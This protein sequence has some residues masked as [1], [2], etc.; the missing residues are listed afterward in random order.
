MIK[1]ILLVITVL[2]MLSAMLTDT[3]EEYKHFFIGG[4]LLFLLFYGMFFNEE[5]GK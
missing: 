5:D 2:G 4:L 3:Q 1:T